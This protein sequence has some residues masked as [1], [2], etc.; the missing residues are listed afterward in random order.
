MHNTSEVIIIDA[1]TE[2]RL[3]SLFEIMTKSV[4]PWPTEDILQILYDEDDYETVVRCLKVALK[5]RMKWNHM[6]VR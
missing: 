1:D 3:S 4:G 6:R 5:K 2:K